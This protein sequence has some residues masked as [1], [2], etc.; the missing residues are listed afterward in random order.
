MSIVLLSQGAEAI[1]DGTWDT[2]VASTCKLFTAD[3]Y[4]GQTD[5]QQE[6]LT[7]ASFTEA[8][9]AGYSAAALT[10]GN[11]TIVAGYPTT[12]T[13][14]QVTFTAS[15]APS[16]PAGIHGYYVTRDSDGKAIWFEVFDH[17]PYLF[18]AA[19]ASVAFQPTLTL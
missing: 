7:E 6:A 8:S 14:T 19:S 18:Y 11:W 4:S 10:S 1:L 16:T 3:I 9:F 13:H 2:T 12:A 17:G 15:A 5:A